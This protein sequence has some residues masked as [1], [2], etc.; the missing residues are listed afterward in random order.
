VDAE[1]QKSTK[2]RFRT[3]KSQH[4]SKDYV[5]AREQTCHQQARQPA[6]DHGDSLSVT[7]ET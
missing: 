1:E 6:C 2:G 7:T 4:D 3:G 5:M